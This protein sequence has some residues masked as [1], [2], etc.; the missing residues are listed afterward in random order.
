VKAIKSV[1]DMR[2]EGDKMLTKLVAR[3]DDGL[4]WAKQGYMVKYLFDNIEVYGGLKAGAEYFKAVGA[5]ND[6]RSLN[7]TADRV[8]K[9][10]HK[11]FW[12]EEPKDATGKRTS[13]APH[14]SWAKHQGPRLGVGPDDIEYYKAGYREQGIKSSYPHALAQLGGLAWI[15]NDMKEHKDLWEKLKQ[16][17]KPDKDN[18]N[19]RW[20]MAALAMN[21]E[22]A[23]KKYEADMIKEAMTF[24]D[25][26]NIH[27]P[28]VVTLAI[29]A[30]RH[31]MPNIATDKA[32]SPER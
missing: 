18:P 26:T 25:K 28:A 30:G 3:E 31:W 22:E 20:L 12:L 16:D 2:H 32:K 29:T 11:T 24:D 23:I 17:F 14:F 8:G 15:S 10:L 19:E 6:S 5:E 13:D 27:R 9:Q 21:D 7:A 1:T 4:T